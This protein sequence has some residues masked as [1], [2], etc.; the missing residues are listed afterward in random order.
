MHRRAS[1]A[2]Y[3]A[4]AAM[5]LRLVGLAVAVGGCA[6]GRLPPVG[7][8]AGYRLED[9]ERRLFA[10][11]AMFEERLRREGRLVR[12]PALQAYV[13]GVGRRM[14]PSEAASRLDFHFHVIRDPTINAFALA[15]GGVYVHTGLLARLDNEAQLAQVLGHEVTHVVE[16]H[17]LRSKRSTEAKTVAAKMTEFLIV[18]AATMFGGGLGYSLTELLI[19]LTHAAAVNGYGRAAE[20]EADLVGTRAMAAAGYD[21]AEAPKLYQLL[22]EGDDP[23]ALE[24][25]FYGNHPANRTR[26]DYVRELVA[27]GEVQS[28]GGATTNADAFLGATARA[29]LDDVRLR[30]AAGHAGYALEE[31]ALWRRHHGDATDA[32]LLEGDARLALATDP[33]QGAREA[34]L[35]KRRREPDPAVV[36]RLR[37]ESGTQLAQAAAAYRRALERVPGL[38]AAHRGLGFTMLARGARDEARVELTR[39]LELA[40]DAPDR[41]TIERRLKEDSP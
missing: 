6:L 28:A 37:A 33:E 34:A 25:F 7:A 2:S 23:G 9:D 41:R 21:V 5:T 16:R 24:V 15:N 18:P 13:A 32:D 12:D 27:S 39:Y 22:G 11:S 4:A 17:A 10:D 8:D 26:C 35:R 19:G 38:P 31:V 3:L 40:P 20:R 1:D 14:V 36:E 29:A 30:L